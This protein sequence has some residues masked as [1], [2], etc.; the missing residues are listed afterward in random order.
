[1]ADDG[2][3]RYFDFNRANLNG[4]KKTLNDSLVLVYNVACIPL[5]Y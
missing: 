1:M 5:F 3:S 4:E 2:V